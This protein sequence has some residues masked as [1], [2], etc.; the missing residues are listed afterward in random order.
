MYKHLS[1][2]ERHQTHSLLKAKQT[3]SHIARLLDRHRSTISRELDRGRGYRAEQACFKASERAQ[4]SRNARRLDPKVWADVDFYLGIQWSTE[5]IAGKVAVSHE[6]VYLHV[7]ANKACGGDL[8]TH[9]RSQNPRRKRHLCERDRRGQIPNHRPISKRPSHIEDRKQVGH[10]EGDTVIGAALKQAI[11]TLVERKSGFAVLA[12]VLN[13]FADLV[14][15]AIDAKLK[16][17]N[18]RMKTLTVDNGKEFADHQ[19]ID[20]SLGIQTYFADPYC[21]WQRGSNENFDGLLRQYIPNKR[22]MET[23]TDEELTMIE[24][25]LNHRPRK[26]L[27]FNTPHEV[28]HASLNRVAVCT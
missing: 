7:Y 24:N 16:P 22:R 9:L 19:A 23:V 27:G 15:Q 13:K 4:R 1:R 14:G 20:Q 11:V 12:K 21:R 8:Q 25:R 17:L 2:D 5:Q 6:S 3:I 28:F 10:W 18:A 26:R